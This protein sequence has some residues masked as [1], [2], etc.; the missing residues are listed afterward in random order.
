MQ[1][2]SYGSTIKRNINKEILN[3]ANPTQRILTLLRTPVSNR[4]AYVT[5]K[6]WLEVVILELQKEQ[7][8][9]MVICENNFKDAK[10]ESATFVFNNWLRVHITRTEFF[11]LS[12]FT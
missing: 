1:S 10:L 3:S 7:F 2:F 4:V 9:L 11:F 12:F 6:N 5:G 8:L